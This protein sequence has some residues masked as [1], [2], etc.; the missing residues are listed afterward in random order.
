MRKLII[1][2]TAVLFFLLPAFILFGGGTIEKVEP[3]AKKEV[4]AEPVTLEFYHGLGG[5][6]GDVLEGMVADFNESQDK[7]VIEPVF[8][9]DYTTL[10]QKL[11]ASIAAGNPPA[12]AQ[13]DDSFLGRFAKA[14][15]LLPMNDFMERPNF[16]KIKDDYVAGFIKAATYFGNIYGLPMQ[17]STPAMYYRKDIF[18]EYGIDPNR[19]KTWEGVRDVSIELVKKDAVKYGFEPLHDPWFWISYL[20]IAGGEWFNQDYTRATFGSP[21]G[22]K[23]FQF[24]YDLI[25]KYKVAYVHYGGSGW[26]YWYDT[27]GDMI[28]G[29]CAM[30]NGSTGDQGD[31][32]K[33]ASQQGLDPDVIVLSFMPKFE[34]GK[35]SVPF[36][37]TSGSILKDVPSEQQ[38]G[39]W[40]FLLWFSSPKQTAYWSKK[41]GY[42][43]TRYS[44]EKYLNIEE[45]PNAKVALDQLKYAEPAPMTPVWNEIYTG[46]LQT[47]IDKICLEKK[48][49]DVK[50]AVLEAQ[51]EA[52][53]IIKESQ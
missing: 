9:A 21:E 2:L 23:M 13:L 41:T 12:L 20:R 25:H 36:G 42:L 24:F 18:E 19:I 15:V 34:G 8:N 48:G 29:I 43:P 16:Q 1:I 53:R 27:E 44:A 7:Y 11:Q 39:A 47:L 6:L 45:N 3:E 46:P 31:L 32:A 17:R 37:G 35:Y 30:Y 49:L 40:E 52:N 10:G 14:G 5:F 33:A 22:I 4:R 51:E 50:K 38:E 26:Q 28:N